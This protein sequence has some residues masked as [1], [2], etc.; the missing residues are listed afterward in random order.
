MDQD[1][2]RQLEGNEASVGHDLLDSLSF[3]GSLQNG[4]M[5]QQESAV[6][7]F[8]IWARIKSPVEMWV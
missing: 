8:C 2:H 6:L 5:G 3:F 7:T 4:Y 1:L